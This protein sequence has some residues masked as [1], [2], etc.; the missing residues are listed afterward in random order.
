MAPREF[1]NPFALPAQQYTAFKITEHIIECQHIREW[2]RAIAR[3]QDD[4]LYMVFKQ[5]TP[6]SN[7]TRKDGD[8]TIIAIP[9]NATP[10]EVYEPLWEDLVL[11]C[12]AVGVW[13][14]ATLDG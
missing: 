3:L 4:E 11:A 12:L 7:L 9:A 8:L 13:A 5:Y 2:P 1:Y 10:K 14:Y 6:L